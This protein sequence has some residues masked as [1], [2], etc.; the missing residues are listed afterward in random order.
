MRNKTPE[1][2]ICDEIDIKLFSEAEQNAFY[3]ALLTRIIDLFNDKKTMLNQRAI[4]DGLMAYGSDKEQFLD[5]VDTSSGFLPKNIAMIHEILDP[6]MEPA[7]KVPGLG[8]SSSAQDD[9]V[10]D[11]NTVATSGTAATDS[12][13]FNSV[14]GTDGEETD[15]DLFGN[16]ASAAGT[17]AK[18]SAADA[19]NRIKSFDFSL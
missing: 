19:L 9:S 12:A 4:T 13:D 11:D 10:V 3:N 8:D 14:F 18:V 17:A 5:W 16:T 15:S 6:W 1:I 2:T 7:V